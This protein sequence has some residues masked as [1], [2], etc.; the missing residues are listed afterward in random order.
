VRS[1]IGR[2]DANAGGGQRF[3]LRCHIL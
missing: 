1:E 3:Q 2:N